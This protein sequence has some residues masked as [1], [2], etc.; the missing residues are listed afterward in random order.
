MSTCG[1]LLES[2]S[3]SETVGVSPIP[4]NSFQKV[5]V[6]RLR[7]HDVN[8]MGALEWPLGGSK[9]LTAPSRDIGYSVC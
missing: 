3:Y 9:D 6:W 4:V 8:A 7:C 5:K 2:I 1:K